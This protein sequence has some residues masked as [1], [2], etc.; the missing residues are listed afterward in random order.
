MR[1][2]KVAI[3]HCASCLLFFVGARREH[4]GV[5]TYF[6]GYKTLHSMR[7]QHRHLC[8]QP[9]KEGIVLA[10][11]KKQKSIEFKRNWIIDHKLGIVCMCVWVLER[12]DLGQDNNKAQLALC[13]LCTGTNCV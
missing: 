10:D 2:I 9:G 6:T 1:H 12:N 5:K 3:T 11:S 7:K 8:R 13:S 4:H